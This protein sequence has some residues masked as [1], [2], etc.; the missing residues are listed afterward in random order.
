MAD[1]TKSFLDALCEWREDPETQAMWAA[2]EKAEKD[3]ER[4][5]AAGYPRDYASTK[6]M[7][8]MVRVAANGEVS[9]G[10]VSLA[11]FHPEGPVLAM[12]FDQTS[13]ACPEQYDV[14][15]GEAQVGYLRLRHGAFRVDYPECG[16]ETIYTAEPDGDG[17]FTNAERWEYLDRARVAIY[18]RHIEGRPLAPEVAE[19]LER[20]R[21]ARAEAREN[22]RRFLAGEDI[23]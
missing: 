15:I 14:F 13:F 5:W 18:E 1:D 10:P 23:E 16:G 19:M 6:L 8:A 7:G 11:G 12:R 9:R 4:A 22:G 2:R 3:A 17:E 21:K 20:S